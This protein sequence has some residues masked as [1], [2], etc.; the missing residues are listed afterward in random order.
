MCANTTIEHRNIALEEEVSAYRFVEYFITE[1]TSE[2]EI[3]SIEDAIQNT[4]KFKGAKKHLQTSLK[5]LSDRKNPD[6][7]NSIKESISAVESICKIITGDKKATLGK[8]LGILGKKEK[9]HQSLK[10]G[11]DKFYGYTSDADGIRHALLDEDNLSFFD[12]K[13][14]L[15]S[16][17]AFINYLI[18]K[19]SI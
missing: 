5:L 14:M 19:L 18:G 4:D 10:A 16:C 9:I 2:E 1:I 3:I 8:A 6:Y 11:F 12:A 17:S 7:R 15:V 13:F